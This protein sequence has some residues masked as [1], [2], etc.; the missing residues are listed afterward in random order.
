MSNGTALICHMLTSSFWLWNFNDSQC[1]FYFNFISFVAAW[2]L[3]LIIASKET[4]LIA[5]QFSSDYERRR[6]IVSPST[7]YAYT[8]VCLWW[9]WSLIHHFDYADRCATEGTVSDIIIEHYRP[10]SSSCGSQRKQPKPDRYLGRIAHELMPN[11]FI[12]V[13]NII[14]GKHCRIVVIGDCGC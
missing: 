3:N 5:H 11:D 9:M 7:A 4:C 6:N 2:S 1:L 13:A 14:A 12:K 8:Y 10:S